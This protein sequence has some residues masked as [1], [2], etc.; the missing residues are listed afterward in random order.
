M[1]YRKL[2]KDSKF[3]Q[4]QVAEKLGISKSTLE[5]F[6]NNPR[7]R[8]NVKTGLDKLFNIQYKENREEPPKEIH[9]E[10]VNNQSS[11]MDNKGNLTANIS[12][13]ES[14][15]GKSLD[16]VLGLFNLDKNKWECVGYEAKSW[17]V[18]MKVKQGR[19]KPDKVVT[20]TN[21][22]VTAKFKP[23]NRIVVTPEF[24]KGVFDTA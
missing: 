19:N 11:R 6:L 20:K 5:R 22:G 23:I 7:S 9:F 4:G 24:I 14:A 15:S 10:E 13:K 17:D 1:N 21:H 2:I 16:E 3:S 8:A 12:L 18:T